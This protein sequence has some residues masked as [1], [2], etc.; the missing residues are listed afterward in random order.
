MMEST[1]AEIARAAGDFP[2]LADNLAPRDVEVLLESRILDHGVMCYTSRHIALDDAHNPW[3]FELSS[4]EG[5][6]DVAWHNPY[7]GERVKMALA[8]RLQLRDGL[9]D[10]TRNLIWELTKDALLAE[11]ATAPGGAAALVMG[12]G[13]GPA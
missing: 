12:R 11:L 8:R 10:D 13:K 6:E 2:A 3:T 4:P 7:G 1:V 9:N 5:V